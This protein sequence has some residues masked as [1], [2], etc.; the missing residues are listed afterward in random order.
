VARLDGDMYESTMD[1]LIHLWPK[2]SVGGYLIIDDYHGVS[3]CKE[4]VTDFR[5][6]H[7]ITDEIQTIDWTGAFWKKS[8]N[9]VAQSNRD[10]LPVG[11]VRLPTLATDA[12]MLSSSN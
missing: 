12:P 6:L 4:A 11:G 10:T 3:M 1:A 5:K 9:K 2:L 8:D 7:G